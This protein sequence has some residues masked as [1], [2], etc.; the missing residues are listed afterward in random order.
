[1]SR[2]DT[3]DLT[4]VKAIAGKDIIIREQHRWAEA[5]MKPG[6][7]SKQNLELRSSDSYRSRRAR[8]I[9]AALAMASMLALS[10][11]LAVSEV[12]VVD[13]MAVAKGYRTSEL[14]GR[15]VSQLKFELPY[16][17]EGIKVVV[18]NG[19]VTLE[20]EAEWNYQR[21]RAESAVR[22]LRGVVGVSNLIKV[23]PRVSP[24]EIK[25]KI[26]DAFR[27][28]AQLDANRI[29]VETNDGE[30]VLR[31]TV[32]SWAECDEAQRAAWLAPGVTKVDNRITISY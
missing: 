15:A 1:M 19:W 26:E 18:K 16:S 6:S 28:S 8:A 7:D 27:R 11:Q 29:T 21:E 30:V 13:L 22:H 3:W 10:P 9:P 31:G 20:G 32:R 25:T 5:T 12:I 4:L 24:S 14:T 2:I 23:K 17:Y